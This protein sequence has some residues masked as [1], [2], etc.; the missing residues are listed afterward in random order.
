M[1]QRNLLIIG[2]LLIPILAFSQIREVQGMK[3][4]DE[5]KRPVFRG[6]VIIPNVGEYHVLK[7]DFH[8]HTVFSDGH[9]WQI[10]RASCRE[11]V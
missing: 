2:F 5:N 3:Y 1:K 6:N 10:G 9:V 7:C 11:R 8:T 4:L